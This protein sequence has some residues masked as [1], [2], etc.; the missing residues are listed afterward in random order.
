MQEQSKLTQV[1]QSRCMTKKELAEATGLSAR[2][3]YR[4]EK[5]P[6]KFSLASIRTIYRISEA[7]GVEPKDIL[8]SED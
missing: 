2:T 6:L 1:R 4:Y 5:S 3:I 8:P 7:L